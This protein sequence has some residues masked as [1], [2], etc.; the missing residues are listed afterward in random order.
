MKRNWTT[1]RKLKSEKKN[2]KKQKIYERPV[3]PWVSQSKAP[4]VGQPVTGN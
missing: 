2:K 4:V 1:Q 3:D